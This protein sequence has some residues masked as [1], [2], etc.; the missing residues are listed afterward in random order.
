MHKNIYKLILMLLAAIQPTAWASANW[1]VNIATLQNGSIVSSHTTASS[2]QQVTLTVVPNEYCHLKA[3]SLV[4]ENTTSEEGD[5]PTFASRRAPA[6]GSFVSLSQTGTNTYSF[7]MPDNDVIVSALFFEEG[8]IIVDVETEVETPGQSNIL[9]IDIEPD[10]DTFTATINVVEQK[11]G[12][13][14]PCKVRLPQSVTDA[15]G[16]VFEVTTVA[17]YAF[18]GQ[19]N[20]T[21]IYLPETTEP[22]N[23]E[24]R[25]FLLDNETGENHHV[26]IIHTPI[27]LL[28]DYALME[29]FSENYVASKMMGIVTTQ[30]N[31]RTLACGVDVKVPDNITVYTIHAKDNSQVVLNALG[32]GITIKANNGV[33][34]ASSI[35]GRHTYEVTAIPSDD[36]P[37]GMTP[38]TD[39]AQTYPNNLLIPVV[40][41][42]HFYAQ[43]N[44]YILKNNKFYPISMEDADKCCPACRAILHIP[45]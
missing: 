37:S 15:A 9:S 38:P 3:G 20:I 32:T 8:G 24:A 44:Y 29:I 33:I 5:H 18:F 13:M 28:D 41:E 4:V 25:A 6:V 34:L 31:Y 1:R 39:N 26:P 7:E 16:N 40:S 36:R 10:Y 17:A 23:I 27:T 22:M 14:V 30:H 2:G 19:T 12:N 43:R 42:R 11:S 35:D 21:D 45:Y